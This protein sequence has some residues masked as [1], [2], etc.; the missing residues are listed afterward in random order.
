MRADGII[1]RVLFASTALTLVVVAGTVPGRAASDAEELAAILANKGVISAS[2]ARSIGSAPQAA[3]HGRLVSILRKKGVLADE[4]LKS[5]RPEARP[6]VASPSPNVS[7]S[8]SP[9]ASTAMAADVPHGAEPMFRK[10]AITVGGFEITPVGYISLATVTRSTNTGNNLSTNFGAIP[11]TNTISGNLGETRVSAQ[12][13]RLG[14]RAHSAVNSWLDI[15]GYFEGDF[16]GND[17]AN[18]F[19]STNSH[20]FRVR[21]AYADVNAGQFEY[22]AGQTWGWLTPNRKGIGPDSK[23]VFTTLNIDPGN[24]VGLPYTRAGAVHVAW[25]PTNEI[26]LGA[27]IENPEQYVGAGEVTF[28]FAFNAQLGGQFD[29]ANNTATPNAFP[30]V[31]GKAT[32]DTEVMDRHIHFEAAGMWREFKATD[33]PTGG[34]GFVSHNTSGWIAT[35]AGNVEVFKGFNVLGNVFWSEGGGRYLTGLGPDLVVMPVQTGP[36][37][38]DIQLSDVKSHAFLVGAEWQATANTILAGYYGEVFFDMNAFADVTSPLLV[39]PSIGFGGVNSPNAANK[40]V[41][42]WTVDL[43]HTYWSDPRLGALQ[44]LLQYSYVQRE[45]WF[46]ANGAPPEARTHM[47]FSEF[48]YLFPG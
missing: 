45:A 15:V 14:L 34:T 22:T 23:N 8:V 16:L 20:T 30:D 43:K 27:G 36:G 13:T 47:L 11:Y 26:A 5:L 3:Q 41:Q 18:V 9:S 37:N 44:S 21:L 46:V 19:V 1:R 33:L 32:Y 2:E 25:H 4:D 38:F 35:A 6:Q 17:A 39:K 29:A 28:P 7:S 42:E 40:S 24:Q 31:V 10:A 48:R 12:A